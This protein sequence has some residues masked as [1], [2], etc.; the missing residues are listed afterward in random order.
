MKRIFGLALAAIA[1]SGCADMNRS[2]GFN[3]ELDQRNQQIAILRHH[4]REEIQDPSL[5][6]IREKVTLNE[7]YLRHASPCA[8]AIDDSYPT[9]AEQATIRKWM[10]ERNDFLTRLSALTA[11]V[12]AVSDRYRVMMANFDANKFAYAAQI[13]QKITDL[14]EG[15]LTYCQFAE[16]SQD[17]NLQAHRNALAFRGQLSEEGVLDYKRRFGIAPFEMI[18]ADFPSAGQVIP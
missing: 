12:S 6:S 2:A 1:L 9:P 7:S 18:Y 13:T 8:G 10:G 15:R 4:Y 5:N 3:Q 17:I 11:P 16:A 14:A